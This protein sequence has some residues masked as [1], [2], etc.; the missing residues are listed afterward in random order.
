MSAHG[1]H[2]TVA[3][4]IPVWRCMLLH[5]LLT[6]TLSNEFLLLCQASFGQRYLSFG[7]R[8][9][10]FGHRYLLFGHRLVDSTVWNK[11]QG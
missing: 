9:L 4:R 1:D 6:H 8:Y 3:M 11:V 10:S 7:H 5:S 2:G